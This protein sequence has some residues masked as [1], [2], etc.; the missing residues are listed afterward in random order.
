[1][2]MSFLRAVIGV[3][4]V[5]LLATW[6][7][8]FNLWSLGFGL[9]AFFATLLLTAWAVGT[10]VSGLILRNGMGAENLAWTLMFLIMPVT[11]V[12]YPVAVLPPFVQPIAWALPPT[13]VFEGLRAIL[14]EHTFRADLMV[15]ALAI[16]IGL[17]IVAF[18]VFLLLLV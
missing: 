13:Y 18:P 2:R 16:K 3:V 14:I 5:T 8:G 7:F 1:M 9:G 17:F 10:I 6:F 11:A 15:E 4:P 12:F